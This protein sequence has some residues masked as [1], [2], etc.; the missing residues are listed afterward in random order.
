MGCERYEGFYGTVYTL[1]FKDEHTG[2]VFVKD[3]SSRGAADKFCKDD[4]YTFSAA[5]KHIDR[6][7]QQIVLGGRLSK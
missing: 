7:K 3:C 5:V 2:F 1:K 6:K 4:V